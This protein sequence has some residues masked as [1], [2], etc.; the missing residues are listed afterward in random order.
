METQQMAQAALDR[1]HAADRLLPETAFIKVDIMFDGIRYTKALGDAAAT[2]APNF[3]PY[4]FAAGEPDPTGTGK[5][6]IPYLFTLED[7]TLI[8]IKGNFLSP[9]HIEA[10]G[11]GGHTLFR[12]DKAMRAIEFV[13]R[14]RWLDMHAHDGT[15]LAKTGAEALGDMLVINIAPG[16][17]YFT[18]KEDGESMKCTF[19]G[20]G[21]PD[22]RMVSLGQKIDRTALEPYTITRMKETIAAA[23]ETEQ[24]RH[25]YLVGG[26]LT[27][28]EE[29]GKR[30]L[31][32]ARAAREVVGHKAHLSL[33]SGALPLE[34]L[35]I[36]KDEDLVDGACFNLEVWGKKLFSSVCPG[37][38]KYVGWE[39]WLESLYA[40]ADM[41]GLGNVYT[42][43][44]CGVELE[45][46]H[47]GMTVDEGIANAMEGARELLK[48][49]VIPIWSMYWPIWG[50]THPERLVT[51]REYYERLN[52]EYAK[53]R[54][55]LGIKISEKFQCRRCAYMQLE[56][57]LDRTF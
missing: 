34:Q 49:N 4:R 16:C 54:Q 39:K 3:Y 53:V 52:A 47:G 41:F 57:D 32:M 27:D 44:V 2:S 12:D 8:R 13:K 45:P 43:L 36:F 37:K 50:M 46:E 55:E 20:Y 15:S 21:R 28:W 51:L 29:E 48:H 18:K 23:M 30:F 38:Q 26:S 56:V 19:C 40:A 5:A 25:V 9:W 22:E 42:A 7:G 1:V 10:D 14:P 33:G 31:T 24:P 11:K 6:P 35:K 17:Q